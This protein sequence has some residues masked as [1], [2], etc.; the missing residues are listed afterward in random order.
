VRFPLTP[1]LIDEATRFA[2]RAGCAHCFHFHARSGGCAS[3]WPLEGQERF[4]LDAPTPD[5]TIPSEVV[6]CREFELA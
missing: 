5:G 1:S 4:P 6:F 2:L 3:G